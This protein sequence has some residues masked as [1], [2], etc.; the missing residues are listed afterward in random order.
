MKGRIFAATLF[1]ALALGSM[2]AYA[3]WYQENGSWRY[4]DDVRHYNVENEWVQTNGV[5][6]YLDEAGIMAENRAIYDGNRYYYMGEGGAMVTS[7]W[8]KTV[9]PDSDEL[10][11]TYFDENGKAPNDG[12]KQIGADFYHFTNGQMDYGLLDADGNM[13]N[14]TSEAFKQAVYYCGNA[15]EGRRW[16]GQWLA[17]ANDGSGYEHSGSTLWLYFGSNGKK[18]A[19]RRME[20]RY[21]DGKTYKCSFDRNGVLT[22]EQS[23]SG[24]GS[25]ATADARWVEKV[26]SRSQNARDYENGTKRWFYQN[27]SGSYV[28][29]QMKKISGNFYL[30]DG[31]GIMR[32]GLVLVR[33]N[34]FSETLC[35][36]SDDIYMEKED[37]Q[38]RFGSGE[39]YYFDTSGARKSGRVSVE[40]GDDTYVMGFA[41]SGKALDGVSSNYLYDRGFLVTA[42]DYKYRHVQVNGKDYLVNTA[43][44]VMGR[45]TY[46]DADGYKY[47]VEKDGENYRI[48]Q[49]D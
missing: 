2:S 35:N 43:G 20:I 4:Y 3:G 31:S 12:W 40:L 41:Q 22:D 9:L 23:M 28:K 15:D 26:P 6:Y 10:R 16:N 13:L 30:F 49:V 36:P 17:V 7:R 34:R 5:W 29:D 37:V 18:V 45:G 44:K 25:N 14:D 48:T 21:A 42:E 46:T 33:D 38:A 1:A 24:S 47:K 8:V 32:T 19:D 27:A 11:W 39:I